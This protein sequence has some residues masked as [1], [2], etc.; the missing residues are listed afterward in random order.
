MKFFQLSRGHLY[1]EG[2]GIAGFDPGNKTYAAVVKRIMSRTS[3]YDTSLDGLGDETIGDLAEALLGIDF[4]ISSD[5]VPHPGG[6]ELESP[7]IKMIFARAR[8]FIMKEFDGYVA[9]YRDK[10][11]KLVWEEETLF[12]EAILMNQS[13]LLLAG[14]IEPDWCTA[15][16]VG[17]PWGGFI[18]G[19]MGASLSYNLVLFG[20]R[21]YALQQ[22]GRYKP[23]GLSRLLHGDSASQVSRNLG[24]VHP[25]I[26]LPLRIDLGLGLGGAEV[27]SGRSSGCDASRYAGRRL[28]DRHC[29]HCHRDGGVHEEG[30]PPR[31]GGN[32]A[33]PRGGAVCPVCRHQRCRVRS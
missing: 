7:R 32:C 26:G 25:E 10:E 16:E 18:P 15:P 3:A 24:G 22:Q 2:C 11:G 29:F 9:D 28:R 1:V 14:S 17:H 8:T 6:L 30:Q 31:E 5:T 33:Q 21:Q 4:L 12:S 13:E 23:T 19:P 27:G 20:E